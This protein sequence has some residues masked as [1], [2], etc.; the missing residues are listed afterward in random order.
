[1]NYNVREDSV[2]HKSN[3]ID[4]E[5]INN[6]I[7]LFIEKNNNK[8]TFKKDLNTLMIL[9]PSIVQTSI[10]SIIKEYNDYKKGINTLKKFR[11]EKNIIK[12]FKITIFSKNSCF[13]DKIFSIFILL[14]MYYPILLIRE[15]YKKIK[16]IWIKI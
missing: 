6:T 16:T 7:N 12:S 14:K 10:F 2:S 1:M 13:K 8:I 3:F 15:L 9:I 4:L 5:K 11:K